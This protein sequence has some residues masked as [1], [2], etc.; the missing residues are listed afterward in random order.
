MNKYGNKTNRKKTAEITRKPVI[1]YGI[2]R[3]GKRM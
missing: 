3:G 2:A 1:K